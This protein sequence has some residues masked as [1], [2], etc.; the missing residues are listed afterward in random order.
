MRKTLASLLTIS[1][2]TWSASS[3]ACE[4]HQDKTA[5]TEN[6]IARA[7]AANSAHGV[8]FKVNKMHCKGCAMKIKKALKTDLGL[9]AVDIDLETK[10][11]KVACP[12]EGCS[13]EKITES[14]AKINYPIDAVL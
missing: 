9:T 10:I 2:L 3:F 8:A 13:M 7:V 12:A 11:V 5:S 4:E 14:L 1:A 6:P